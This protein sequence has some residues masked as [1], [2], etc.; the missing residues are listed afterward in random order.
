MR[1][2]HQSERELFQGI[3]TSICFQKSTRE[4]ARVFFCDVRIFFFFLGFQFILSL[5]LFY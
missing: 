1:D 3:A 2:H 4:R 5:L